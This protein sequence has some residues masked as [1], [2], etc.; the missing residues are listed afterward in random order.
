MIPII[1][2]SPPLAMLLALVGTTCPVAGAE[3]SVTDKDRQ[4][5]AFYRLARPALPRNLSTHLVRTSVDAFLL[6]KLEQKGLTFS[7]DADRMT[8]IRRASL[9]LI[10][11]P[12]SPQETDTFLADKR[13]DAYERL[14]DRLL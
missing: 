7:P 5:W 2:R 8:M 9:D 1:R 3:S 4:H 10:G 12:P 6:T 11:L 13:P 14:L